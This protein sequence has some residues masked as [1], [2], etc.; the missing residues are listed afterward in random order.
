VFYVFLIL[1]GILAVGVYLL[2]I[3][4]QVPGA[5]EQRL[6]VLE[7]LP[8]DLGKW[9]IDEDSPEAAAA[10]REGQVR[11]VRVLHYE[12]TGF[13]HGRLVE[14]VRYRS[15]ETH[16]IVRVEPERE[17]KRKRVKKGAG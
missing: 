12:G 15:A 1:V 10:K 14:Q 7:P 4:S 6:G 5:K 11:E 9:K 16:E 17:L 3:F 13:S 2:F 8:A